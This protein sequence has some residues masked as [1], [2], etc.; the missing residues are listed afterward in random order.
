MNTSQIPQGLNRRQCEN[1][2]MMLLDDGSRVCSTAEAAALQTESRA[3]GQKGILV[4]T[5]NDIAVG[6]SK[7][8][9]QIRGEMIAE[10]RK[11]RIQR[12]KDKGIAAVQFSTI[13]IRNYP[14]AIGDNPAS[15]SGPSLSI[16]WGFE[17][18]ETASVDNYEELLLLSPRR[19]RME[20]LMPPQV[21]EQILKRAGFTKRQIRE[22]T[23]PVNICRAQ[24]RRTICSLQASH[25]H[26][27]SEKCWRKTLN[28]LSLGG[29]KRKEKKFLAE[30]Q[31]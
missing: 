7:T 8:H 16:A 20:M 23:K 6:N 17:S 2:T 4:L 5:T 12:T 26:E 15:R 1:E 22:V 29:R 9:E 14:Y 30:C 28:F 19:Q 25:L 21:R 24:R 18:E 31:C 27:I 10:S 11:R 3:F 13:T